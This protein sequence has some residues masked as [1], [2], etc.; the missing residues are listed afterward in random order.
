MKSKEREFFSKVKQAV[1]CNPFNPGRLQLDLELTGLPANTPIPDILQT[2][3]QRVYQMLESL[4][5][6]KGGSL[7]SLSARDLQLARYGVLFHLFHRYADMYED[8]IQKQIEEGDRCC[9]VDFAPELLAELHSYG[10]N[11][12]ESVRYLALFFQM[13]RGY[14]FIRQISGKTA[15]VRKVRERLWNNIFTHDLE[16]YHD[17]LW[18][19]LEDFSTMLLGETGTGKGLAAS[20]IGRSGFIPFDRKKG[21]FSESFAKSF[22]SINLS[23]FPEQ[24]IE[25]E[26]FGHKKGAFTGAVDSHQGVF[27]RCSPHGA[28]FLDE[29]GDVSI[30][31]QVTLLQVLQERRFMPV[32]SRVSERFQGRV[33]AATNKSI[34][35]LRSEG[36]MRDDFYYRLCSDT[37]TIPSLRERLA[38]NGDEIFILLHFIVE[39]ILG[40]PAEQLVTRLGNYILKNQPQNYPWPGNIRELEQCVRR[41]LVSNSY[42]WDLAER[43]EAQLFQETLLRNELTAQQL[44]ASYCHALYRRYG[45]YEAVARAADLDRRTVKKY[46]LD[47]QTR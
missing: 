22:L 15:C 24:L 45:T 10:F 47:Y 35:K 30:P 34:D 18:N 20:A 21:Q 44:I 43:E 3:L 37:I 2:L 41:I 36:N 7:V 31:V 27:S 25:S 11:D 29:I 14:Y 16:L 39:R 5:Q 32:G 12:T 38:E 6:R 40:H 9:F 23:Q 8:H 28:I 26:L 4:L 46:I 17:H 19:R 42:Q 33:I 1:T 13:R